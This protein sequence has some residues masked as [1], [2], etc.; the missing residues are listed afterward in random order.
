MAKICSRLGEVPEE[1]EEVLDQYE[2]SRSVIVQQKCKE[3]QALA[4]DME[5]LAIIFP[6]EGVS[7]ELE[8][9][10]FLP[11]SFVKKASWGVACFRRKGCQMCSL[12]PQRLFVLLTD[13]DLAH[14]S[15]LIW[16]F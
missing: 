8:V 15:M 2:D 11:P 4:K 14:S 10:V 5:L 6:E 12:N 13:R 3:I 9:C 7:Q 1:V 16:D